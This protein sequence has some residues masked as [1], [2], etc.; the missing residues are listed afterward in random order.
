MGGVFVVPFFVFPC[1]LVGVVADVGCGKAPDEAAVFE[2]LVTF[3]T[4]FFTARFSFNF[5]RPLPPFQL[6]WA[7]KAS[8]M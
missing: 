6:P 2:E 5:P 1:L 7:T 8:A 3:F 4:T